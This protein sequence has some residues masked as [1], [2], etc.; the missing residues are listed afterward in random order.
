MKQSEQCI[1]LKIWV[2]MKKIDSSL[3]LKSF[4]RNLTE[5]IKKVEPVGLVDRR[6]KEVMSLYN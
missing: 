4:E 2:E 6:V 5:M 1:K 3:T